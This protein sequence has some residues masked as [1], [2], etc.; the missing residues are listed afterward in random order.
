MG[1]VLTNSGNVPVYALIAAAVLVVL[2][3]IIWLLQRRGHMAF[4]RGGTNRQ[5]RLAVLDAAAVDTRRRL[6]LVRRDNVEH[7]ILIGGPSDVVIESGITR[8]TGAAAHPV[9]APVQE[10]T[11]GV[12]RES[13]HTTPAT[14]A[15]PAPDAVKQ[16]ASPAV[17]TPHKAQPHRRDHAEVSTKAPASRS[18]RQETPAQPEKP[19]PKVPPPAPTEP[20]AAKTEPKPPQAVVE[21]AST[22]SPSDRSR[23]QPETASHKPK[24]TQTVKTTRPPDG[25]G[26][27]GSV[28]AAVAGT[29][30]QI[31]QTATA[32]K[33][34]ETKDPHA[35][36]SATATGSSDAPPDAAAG[37]AATAQEEPSKTEFEDAMDAVRELVMPAT[38]P[39]AESPPAPEPDLNTAVRSETPAEPVQTVAQLQRGE[40]PV[41]D[42]PQ[43]P[44][45]P[46]QDTS[47][48]TAEDLIADFDR[49]LQA[50]M[51]KVEAKPSSQG[52]ETKTQSTNE[53]PAPE[54]SDSENPKADGDDIPSLEDEMK[55]LLGDFSTKK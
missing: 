6:V 43:K 49:V 54:K 46:A 15:T 47:S 8:S 27:K 31:T 16:P 20:A 32:P 13:A 50:E 4:M 10:E 29:S 2:G 52:D 51:D 55:K 7:L 14:P 45:Q 23:T 22:R 37:S 17:G 3:L 5:P 35:P 53:K 24:S 12:A 40:A 41:V 1:E 44:D 25:S 28:P 39:T 21:T 18:P 26:S 9:V 38:T 19:A 42:T 48:I 33:T 30:D 34:T 11:A 36:V